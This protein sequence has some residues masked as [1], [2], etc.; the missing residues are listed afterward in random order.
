MSREARA[1]PETHRITVRVPV[2]DVEFLDALVE[3]GEYT[4]RT[5]IVRRAI[6]DF[7]TE[8]GPEVKEAAESQQA[9]TN[10]LEQLQQM[11]SQLETQREIL[12]EHLEQ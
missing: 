4:S 7:I 1:V 8:Q 9:L 10:A 2:R 12:E 11:Q 5:A 6:R 3:A